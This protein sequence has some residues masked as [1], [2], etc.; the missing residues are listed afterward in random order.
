LGTRL[1]IGVFYFLVALRLE[2]R[3]AGTAN[4][5]D[6]PRRLSSD[7]VRPVLRPASWQ[8]KGA[9][10][11]FAKLLLSCSLSNYIIE[12]L[13]SQPNFLAFIASVAFAPPCYV[14]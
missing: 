12:L 5:F 11:I 3:I 8:K 14:H 13:A 10:F 9:M 4:E 6:K 2:S 1:L 7:L